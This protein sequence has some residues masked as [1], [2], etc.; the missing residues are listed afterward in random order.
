MFSSSLAR[1]QSSFRGFTP[2]FDRVLIQKFQPIQKTSSGLLIPEAAQAKVKTGIVV[3]HGPGAFD[4]N[5]LK[6]KPM[7]LKTGDRVLLPD[8]VGKFEE[9]FEIEEEVAQKAAA[10]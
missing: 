10:E 2:L 8:F 5:D 9:D 6:A 3:A 1:F 7:E 4:N